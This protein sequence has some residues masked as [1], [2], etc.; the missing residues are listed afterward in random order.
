MK[1]VLLSLLLTI[2]SVSVSGDEELLLLDYQFS[3]QDEVFL[4]ASLLVR[5][6]SETSM[7]VPSD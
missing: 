6:Q 3:Y 1:S 4:S 5:E 7:S 2:V